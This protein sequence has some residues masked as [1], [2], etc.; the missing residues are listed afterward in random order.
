[1]DLTT[2]D[3]K[4]FRLL[5][6]A[7]RDYALIEAGDRIAVAVSGGK[8]SRA[9]L[10]LLQERMR[11]VPIRYE[12]TAVHLD[13]GFPGSDTS[14]IEAFC[15]DLNIPFHAEVTDYGPRAH[16]PENRENPCFLCSRLRRKR[17]F[18]IAGSSGCTKL[19][20]GH[21]Q[22]DILETLFL[23]IFYSGEI[24]TMVPRQ[25][26]FEGTL[27]VIRPLALVPEKELKALV[28]R[29]DWPEFA[30]PCPSAVLSRRAEIKNML[31]ALYATNPKIRGNTLGP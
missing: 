2:A 15:R 8:D 25:P 18:E 5:G 9:L 28:G 14:R 23:N 19:A 26:L 20:F 13:P 17:L 3:R 10:W 29:K 16:S 21:N 24:G 27:T 7:I 30:N 31:T 1:M 12:L 4:I 22:D 11:W 6:R